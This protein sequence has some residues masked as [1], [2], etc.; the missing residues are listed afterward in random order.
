VPIF[1]LKDAIGRD[2]NRLPKV[3]VIL[4]VTLA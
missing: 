2:K 3:K 4:V 1:N